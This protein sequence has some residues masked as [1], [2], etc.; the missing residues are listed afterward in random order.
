MSIL[1]MDFFNTKCFINFSKDYEGFTLKKKQQ[2]SDDFCI[3]CGTDY[4]NYIF[5]EIENE[6]MKDEIVNI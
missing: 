1:R 4:A 2:L 5:D 3:D 6:T